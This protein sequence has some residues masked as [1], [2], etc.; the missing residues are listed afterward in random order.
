MARHYARHVSLSPVRFIITFIVI[1]SLLVNIVV[2]IFRI[3]L[4]CQAIE[5]LAVLVTALMIYNVDLVGD[6][7]LAFKT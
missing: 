4:R 2:V 6:I 3:S 5:D 1:A 7:L